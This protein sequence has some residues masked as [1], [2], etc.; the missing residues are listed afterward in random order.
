[1][2]RWI[3]CPAPLNALEGELE[4]NPGFPFL[5]GAQTAQN[6]PVCEKIFPWNQIQLQA[7][8][9]LRST[10][11]HTTDIKQKEFLV[12]QGFSFWLNTLKGLKSKREVSGES[13]G[14]W[15]NLRWFSLLLFHFYKYSCSFKKER[16]NASV[17]LFSWHLSSGKRL[18]KWL[19]KE[20]GI[21]CLISLPRS[22]CSQ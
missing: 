4:K 17:L 7:G 11:P 10:H 21:F 12:P 9:P 20:L 14:N 18:S 3:V 6:L 1:M 5:K 15:C 2:P 19:C 8:A 13:D 22:N 16:S